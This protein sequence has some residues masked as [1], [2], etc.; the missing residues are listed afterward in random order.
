MSYL[1]HPVRG[2]RYL[3]S[4]LWK[5]YLQGQHFPGVQIWIMGI[6]KCL[7]QFLHLVA[8]ENSSEK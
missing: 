8:R 2:S 7:L 1:R 6:F 3:D 4:V 5:I